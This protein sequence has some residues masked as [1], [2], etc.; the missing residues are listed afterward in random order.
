MQYYRHV[1]ASLWVMLGLFIATTAFAQGKVVVS[2][3]ARKHFK[4]GVAYIDDPSGPK[5][6]EAYREFHIAY[7]DSPTYKIMTNIGLCAL[8]LERDE[9]A[10]DAYEKFL[11]SAKAEDIPKDKRVIME[12]DVATLKASLVKIALT[13]TPKTLVLRDERLTSKGGSVINR[14]DLTAGKLNLGI[15][16]GHHRITASAEGYEPQTWDFEADSASSHTHEFTLKSLTAAEPVTTPDPAPKA[17]PVVTAEPETQPKKS[18]PTLVYVGAV[19]TGVFAIGATVTGIIAS[20]KKSD[21]DEKNKPGGDPAQLKDLRDSGKTF[22]LITDIG[23][24]A[25][26]LSAV[27]TAIVYFT[28]PSNETKTPVARV[29][30]QPTV[31]VEQAGL[32]F[33]GQF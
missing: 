24:G 32:S 20:G 12:R 19:A 10:I 5:Y 4:A 30:I 1:L 9:E 22:A 7:A 28:A 17:T 26:V 11:A 3:N 18:T 13:G 33:S 23:I 6:E 29:N 15:H 25:A 8:N 21:Y 14:Y 27:G 31:G 2:E 16:P